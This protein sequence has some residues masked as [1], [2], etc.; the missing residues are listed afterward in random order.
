VALRRYTTV[1]DINWVLHPLRGAT[2]A[3]KGA[4]RRSAV[5]VKRSHEVTPPA[6][7]IRRAAS[8]SPN[9]RTRAAR[10]RPPAAA[11]LSGSS[12]RIPGTSAAAIELPLVRTDQNAGLATIDA[13]NNAGCRTATTNAGKGFGVAVDQGK[14]A[15]VRAT[16][17]SGGSVHPCRSR[18]ITATSLLNA[19]PITEDRSDGNRSAGL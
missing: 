4:V 2:T 16:K 6:P 14:M 13:F 5:S 17:P 7:Q 19:K 9:S 8:G 18:L 15:V 10:G 1:G 3:F 11:R 12:H